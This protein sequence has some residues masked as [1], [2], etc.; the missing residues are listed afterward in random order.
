MGWTTVLPIFRANIAQTDNIVT[1]Q[2]EYVYSFTCQVKLSIEHIQ[3]TNIKKILDLLIAIQKYSREIEKP[4]PYTG[5]TPKIK[6]IY[7][8]AGVR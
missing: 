7:E 5:Y 2:W 4:G 3:K 8:G 6:H 1:N